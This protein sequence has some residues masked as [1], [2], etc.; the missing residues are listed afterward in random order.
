MEG[1]STPVD[2][3]VKKGEIGEVRVVSTVDILMDL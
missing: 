2:V 1:V 3:G